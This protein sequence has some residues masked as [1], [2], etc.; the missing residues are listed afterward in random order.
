MIAPR[1]MRTEKDAVIEDHADPALPGGDSG[2]PKEDLL[3][4]V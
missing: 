1:K 3:R 2:L 4:N